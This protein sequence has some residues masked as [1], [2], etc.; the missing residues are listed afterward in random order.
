MTAPAPRIVVAGGHSAGHIE[1]AMNFADAVRR[2]D[3]T[4][5]ITALGTERGL[6]TTLIPARG[7][8]LELIPP[9][10][11][12]RRLNRALLATPGKL[13]ASVRAA[14][15]VL[16]RVRAEVVVGFGGYVAMPAYV[17]AKRRGLPI[18]IHEAN[19][20][21][22][23]ANRVAARMTTHVFTAA[24]G[25]ALPHAT[26]IGIPL[27]PAI[28]NLDR[29]ALR[30]ESRRRFGLDPDGPVLMVTGGSQGARAINWAV[31]GAAGALRAAGI[32]VL[33]IAG[34]DN[35][36]DVP[37]E[38]GAPPYIVVGYVDSM[39]YAY[40]AAD[41]VVC[42]SGAMTCAELTAV[43][44]PAAYVPLPLR[45]GEQRFNA[46]PI[47]A[48]GGGL[49]VDDADLT[50]AWIAAE[51]I[52]RITD[53]DTLARMTR[54]AR[55]VGARDADVVLARHVL[56]VVAEQ[57]HLDKTVLIQPELTRPEPTQ[58]QPAQGARPT[59]DAADGRPV[60]WAAPGAALVRSAATD[61]VPALADLGRVHIMGIAGAGMSGLARILLERGVSVSGCE[62][63]E[64]ITVSALRALGAEVSIGH[65]PT[66]LEDTDT[67]VYTTAINPRQQEFVAARASGKPV[68][69]RA[70]ALAAALEDRRCIAIAGT[71][72]KTSTTSLLTVGAQACGVDPSFAIGGNL[73]ETGKNAHLGTGELAIVE[74]DESDGSFLLTRPAAAIV[75]NVEADHLENHGDLEGIFQAFEQF[76]DRIDAGGLLL[77]C[78]D[79][80]GAERIAD[81][82]RGRGLRVLSYGEQPGSDVAVSAVAALPDGVEFS[83]QGPGIEARRVRVGALIGRHMALNAAAALAMAADLGLDLDVVT[84]A[85]AEFGGVRRRFESHGEAAGVRVFDDYA[86]H[87]TEVAAELTA[88]RDVVGP[89]GRLIAVFQPG[90][91]SRTQTFAREFATALAIADIAVL[92]DIF[93]AREEPIP[94]VTGATISDLVPLPADQVVY[95]PRYAA[96]PDRIAEIARPGDL[97]LTMGIGDVYL[98]CDDI[99]DTV[100][101]AAAEAAGDVTAAA[102]DAAEGVDG[103][104]GVEGES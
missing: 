51:V 37:A 9:V 99:R 95:E 41:F 44:L 73:Y 98:L 92:M 94:G 14:G 35:L 29:A 7:Y 82:A 63:R 87:P 78:A 34:P 62:A 8:P 97:V 45:G 60:D 102:G 85:W 61:V 72:G 27:R 90:T 96:I 81:Y 75:T 12:P 88:A 49:L 79:D 19:A 68:L 39:Q 17:A 15:A 65:S 80:E 38:A 76:I 74:A 46:E 47:V 2:L 67:F 83:V 40:A 84:R 28:A 20:R 10:P 64:S 101:R 56:A 26:A 23:V 16:D 70:A 50:P 21:P 57:R 32:Q 3:P 1:P 33:H 30:A 71:H 93:P 22:G 104:E 55:Q 58:P 5:E 77:T 43:G 100:G 11:L 13:N 24:P 25:I 4:A 18:V 36:V 103:V 52:P 69:R 31:S 54:A 53:P 89:G 91:F 59:A 6:D 42:R 66:H 86:H 48:A